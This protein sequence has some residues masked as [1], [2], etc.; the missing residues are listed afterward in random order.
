M[1]LLVM[2]RLHLIA[3]N[4]PHLLQWPISLVTSVIRAYAMHL[5]N[6]ALHCSATLFSCHTCHTTHHDTTPPATWHCRGQAYVGAF[7]KRPTDKDTAAK[8]KGE[9]DAAA[10]A[11]AQDATKQQEQDQ[12]KQQEQQQ[13]EAEAQDAASHL[14]E[15]GTFA[16][17]H[18]IMQGDTADSAQLLLL[19]HR[20]I[21]RVST[22]S[23]LCW[24]C[25]RDVLWL[26]AS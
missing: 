9:V 6:T 4:E 5:N 14:Y 7:L 20:R 24:E 13:Q 3:E 10:A 16:Q 17:V 26:R 11:A 23:A 18:T 2:A 22:V 12:Q 25:A 1:M 8:P 19:G 21:K 15:Y